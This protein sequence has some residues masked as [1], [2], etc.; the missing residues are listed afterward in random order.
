MSRIAYGKFTLWA[1]VAVLVSG[2]KGKKGSKTRVAEIVKLDPDPILEK[3]KKSLG[4]DP[5]LEE[6]QDP[7]IKKKRTEPEPRE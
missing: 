5:T 6:N 4:P 2:R 1:A 3:K 7:T